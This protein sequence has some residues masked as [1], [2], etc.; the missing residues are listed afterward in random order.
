MKFLGTV[1]VVLLGIAAVA[2]GPSIGHAQEPGDTTAALPF[3]AAPKPPSPSPAAVAVAVRALKESYAAIPVAER[4]SIQADL[5]WAVNFPGPVDGEYS[6]QLVNS[7]RAFQRLNKTKITGV[8]NP[9]ERQAL[10][11]MVKPMQDQVGWKIVFDQASGTRVGLPMKLVPN[12]SPARAGSL[13]SSAQ[14]QVR[15]ETFRFLAS[16][17]TLA[18]IFERQKREPSERK[19]EQQSLK[20]DSFVLI[21]MQGLKKFHVRGYARSGEVRGIAIL[22]DQAMEV[23]MDQLIAPLTH[24]FQ[25]FATPVNLAQSTAAPRRKVEYGSGIVVTA[26]GHIVTDRQVVDACNS[27]VIPGIGHAELL[28]QDAEN[29]LALLRVYGADDLV[30]IA[31]AGEEAKGSELVVVG[32]ADPNAQGGNGAISTLTTKLINTTSVTGTVT[33]FSQVP[34]PGFS[35]AAALDKSGRFF[36][37]V[38]LRIPVVAGTTPAAPKAMIVPAE[39]IRS[40]VESNNVSSASGQ[41]GIE[42]CKAAV[43][44]VICVRK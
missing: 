4:I 22:Y 26:A 33:S 30:P 2:I 21:G 44:R 42:G 3:G 41:T 31:L 39:V 36:G 1:V 29:E 10:A 27:I 15:I 25:P 8:L 14:G 20:P 32:V 40:F 11:E 18:D 7:V 16:D 35:G 12:T 23:A 19:V 28:A 37:M 13:W 5:V 9:A 17:A 38:G 24:S 34:G 6:E 43:V